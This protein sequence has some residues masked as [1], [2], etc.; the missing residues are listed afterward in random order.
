MKTRRTIRNCPLPVVRRALRDFQRVCPQQWEAL[1]PTDQPSV[2]HCGQCDHDV[3]LCSNDEETL[4]H[5]RAGHCVAREI[6]DESELPR[7]YVVGRPKHVPPGTPE[8][9][10][11][12]RLTQRE[13]GIDNALRNLSAPRSCPRCHYPAPSWRTNCRVCGFA[14]GVLREGGGPDA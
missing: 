13:H 1:T 12:L 3:Y 9:E 4:S 6:P 2:R 10:E 5:A 7:V 11:A 8:Q 14:V